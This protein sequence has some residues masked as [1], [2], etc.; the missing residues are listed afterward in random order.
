MQTPESFS[1]GDTES[2]PAAAMTPASNPYLSDMDDDCEEE[3]TP[4]ITLTNLHEEL[5]ATS[6]ETRRG[7]RR[8]L[9]V[10]K[11][12]GA[13][14]DAL[15]ATVSDTHKAVRA[16]PETNPRLSDGGD[17]PREWALALVELA[18]RLARITEG[19]SR[20]PAAASSWWPGARK[21]LAAWGDAWAMQADAL[22]IL[23]GHLT[24]LL[25]RAGLER[26]EVVGQ[27]FDPNTMTA[28]E[29]AV[30]PVKP[31]HTVLA[32]I[33]PAWRHAVTGQL[34][35]PAH[36]RVSRLSAR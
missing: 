35:R 24:S 34:L 1:Y 4:G 33:L 17:L 3:P 2:P 13:V 23:R 27:P 26:L 16:N 30:D 6:T 14:L 10:L 31:D 5:V 8:M 20:P 19:F 9:E 36:V 12:F 28:V 11:N 22:G 32:E 29:S 15:S 21:S 18:D 7:N 25:R